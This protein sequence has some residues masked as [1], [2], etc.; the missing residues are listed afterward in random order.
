MCWRTHLVKRISWRMTFFTWLLCPAIFRFNIVLSTWHVISYLHS[1]FLKVKYSYKDVWSNANP[2]NGAC[3]ISEYFFNTWNHKVSHAVLANFSFY[4][5]LILIIPSWFT[6]CVLINMPCCHL[7]IY[8]YFYPP[9]SSPLPS[10]WAACL[11]FL[12]NRLISWEEMCFI[13]KTSTLLVSL[14]YL[15][16]QFQFSLSLLFSLFLLKFAL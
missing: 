15:P 7:S 12:R 14:V 9:N 1:H 6:G 2:H 4:T 16:A 13:L 3:L 5:F 8:N 10:L 11:V